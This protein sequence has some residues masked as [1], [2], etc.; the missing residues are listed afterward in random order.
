[1]E[2]FYLLS[3]KNTGETILSYQ[4]FPLTV[5]FLIQKFP[6]AVSSFIT[7]YSPLISSAGS[8]DY[9]IF[10]SHIFC[11]IK[12]LQHILL[13][14]ILQDQRITAYSPLISSAG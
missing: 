7:A 8:K 6:G 1:M 13:S 14:Y 11:R 4:R 9:S 12:G 3:P 2:F 5:K 10:S